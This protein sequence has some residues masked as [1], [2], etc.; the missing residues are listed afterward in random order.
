[1]FIAC[2]NN[3]PSKLRK[4]VA[5]AL[6]PVEG[7]MTIRVTLTDARPLL[8]RKESKPIILVE[9]TKNRRCRKADPLYGY[10]QVARRNLEVLPCASSCEHVL[11]GASPDVSR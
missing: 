9:T 11:G 1:M 10:V 5:G 4:T 3:G 8:K 2:I 6:A 7:R